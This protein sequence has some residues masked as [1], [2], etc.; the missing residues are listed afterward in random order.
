MSGTMTALAPY[1]ATRRSDP[2][3][4]AGG[5]GF[6]LVSAAS[7]G[8]S[9]SLASGL[10]DA[11]WSAGAAVSVRVLIGAV[12]LAVPAVLA[13]RGRWHLLAENAGLILAYGALAVAGCQLFY[14]NAVAHMEVGVAL[15]IEYTAPVMIVGWL[16]LRRGQ[17]PGWRTTTGALVAVVGMVLVLDVVTGAHVSLVGT[18]W[19]F[20]AAVGAAVYFLISA[21]EGNG[22]PPIV[23]AAAGLLVGAAV[24]LAAGAVGLLPMATGTAPVR[25]AGTTTAWWLPLLALGVVT[26]AVAYTSGI[27]ASRRLGSRVASFVALGEVLMALLFAWALLGELP[28]GVQLAGGVL[29]LVGVVVVKLGEAETTGR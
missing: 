5:L 21:D 18:A 1:A 22:L 26:A 9:G 8:L 27:A 4:T 10:M 11:G 17:R 19:G 20:G 15:L 12:V 7:F 16:W 24:L 28:R 6:A 2:L 3:R 29:V 23:L 13:L 25:L 14:F